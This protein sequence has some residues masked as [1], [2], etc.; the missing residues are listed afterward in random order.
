MPYQVRYSE[1]A[2]AEIQTVAC[3]YSQPDINQEAV[4]V[5]VKSAWQR[6][7]TAYAYEAA[8][9]E[10]FWGHDVRGKTGSHASSVQ[11]AQEL[12]GH[13]F[14]RTTVR[15]YGRAPTTVRPLKW[16]Q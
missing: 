10:R 11:R 5:R 13:A 1:A 2:A 8:G 9:F 3:S 15:H 14:A 4:F 12:P 7:M 16:P 6:A